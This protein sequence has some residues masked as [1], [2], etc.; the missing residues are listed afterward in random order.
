MNFT[1][2]SFPCNLISAGRVSSRI[3]FFLGVLVRGLVQIER[4][5]SRRSL[6]RQIWSPT[7]VGKIKLKWIHMAPYLSEL[8]ESGA[9]DLIKVLI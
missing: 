5:S 2:C 1:I 9:T 6:R 7:L 3:Y 8:R 4:S